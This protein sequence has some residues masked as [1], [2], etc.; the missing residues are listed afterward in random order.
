MIELITGAPR[1]GKSYLAVK[2]I[3]DQFFIY[4]KDIDR[5]VKKPNK[6]NITLITN[7][8]GLRLDHISL[9]EAVKSSGLPIQKFFTKDYQQKISKKYPEI[10]YAIDE[11]QQFFPDTFRDTD[12]RFYFEYHG[13]LG[14]H[15]YLITQDR[16]RCCR[17][18]MS[19]AELEIRAVK[20]TLS[21]AGEFKYNVISDGVIID[22]KMIK[23]SK[24]IYRLY[25]S[26]FTQ[27][28]KK[29]GKPFLKY[30]LVPIILVIIFGY[31]LINRFKTD[32]AHAQVNNNNRSKINHNIDIKSPVLPITEKIKIPMEWV[33]INGTA[34][35]NNK[36]YRILCPITNQLLPPQ[37]F[38]Y[39][40]RKVGRTYQAHIPTST[41]NR[42]RS[43]T[44]NAY[45]P[46]PSSIDDGQPGRD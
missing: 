37:Y 23:P 9:D 14:H 39:R 25:R 19:L 36:L 13:H 11:C 18:I 5:F 6:K 30:I 29:P 22:R 26:Q 43:T 16:F 3:L 28:H 35:R 21:I 24:K 31:L 20:R 32:D 33:T 12:T 44:N 42:I 34:H 2:L 4:Q 40:V 46:V 10:I 45:E 38:Q 7:I 1:A 8:E 41:L 15:I 27:E 17:A